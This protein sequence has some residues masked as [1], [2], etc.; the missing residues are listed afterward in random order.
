MS[1]SG[2]PRVLLVGAGGLGSLAGVTLARASALELVVADD[3][4][5]E[6]S[7]LHRQLLFTDADVGAPKVDAAV[8]ALAREA[9]D[10]GSG[11]TARGHAGRFTPASA[12]ALLDGCDVVVEGADNMATKFLVADAAHLAGVPAV[13]AGAVR[14]QGW[15]MAA[16]PGSGPCLRC[17]FE[18]LPRERAETCAEA[19]V[20]GPVVGVLAALEAALALRVVAGD[21]TVR[22]ELWSYD[23]IAGALRRTRVR[24][25]PGC[26]L[27]E[28]RIADLSVERYAAPCA[29]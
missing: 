4:V 23:G 26:P 14:W 3:D 19:G 12:A 13:Q 24:A 2:A 17:V 16:V 21:P 5:V 6:L 11:A 8:A 9:A 18:D 15:A 1:V 20:V 28:G 27:C 29:A 7:N 22:G 25:R 10:A